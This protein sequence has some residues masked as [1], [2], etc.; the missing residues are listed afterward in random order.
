[1]TSLSEIAL[2][3]EASIAA[4]RLVGPIPPEPI[5]IRR[6]ERMRRMPSMNA[7]SDGFM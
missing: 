5:K 6:P 3:A 4:F 1:M 2:V 7:A